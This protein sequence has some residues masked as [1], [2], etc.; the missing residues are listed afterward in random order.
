MRVFDKND[1]N[2][3]KIDVISFV[4]N[5]LNNSEKRIIGIATDYSDIQ[6]DPE[7]LALYIEI[8]INKNEDV[9]VPFKIVNYC[10]DVVESE[11][12]TL[13]FRIDTKVGTIEMEIDVSDILVLVD[14][15]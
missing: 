5:A 8:T 1:I 2:D 15:E 3:K 6:V 9:Y 12:E 14:S 13:V 10:A 7:N 11:K 4:I